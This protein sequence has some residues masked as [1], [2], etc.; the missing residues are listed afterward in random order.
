MEFKTEMGTRILVPKHRSMTWEQHNE[1]C[2]EL[3][4]AALR[5]ENRIRSNQTVEDPPMVK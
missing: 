4:D 3:I 5:N 2:Q 1:M